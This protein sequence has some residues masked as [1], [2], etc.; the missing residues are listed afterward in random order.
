MKTHDMNEFEW[1]DLWCEQHS[2]LLEK[3][4]YPRLVHCCRQRLERD[5]ADAHAVEALAEAYLLNHQ[6]QAA[7]DMLTP[8][9]MRDPDHPLYAHAILD[10]ILAMGKKV[11]DF[12]WKTPPA[13]LDMNEDVLDACCDHLKP[14][15]TPR[16][17]FDLRYLFMGRAYLLFFGG[18]PAPG[19]GCGW[20]IRH[21]AGKGTAGGLGCQT[22]AKI[23]DDERLT[24]G[25]RPCNGWLVGCLRGRGGECVRDRN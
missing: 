6:Q 25:V 11:D 12:P 19:A 10:A 13:V 21:F 2:R 5:P 15:R 22:A 4:D 16:T 8:Y 14:K 17:L 23:A 20:Q 18:R 24:I 9:Y 3:K 7:I 1:F